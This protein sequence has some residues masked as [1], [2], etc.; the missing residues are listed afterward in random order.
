[1]K[2]NLPLPLS[3]AIKSVSRRGLLRTGKVA[4]SV[5]VDLGFDLLYG[6]DTM[7]WIRAKDLGANS[8]Y[9]VNAVRY[10]ATKARPLRKFMRKLDLP[11]DRVFTDLGSGKGRV[12]LI[13]AQLGFEK[14]VGIEFSRRLCDI[15]RQNVKIF[16][17]K[18][19]IT[20][21]IDVIESDVALYN[22]EPEQCIF[23]IYNPFDEVVMERLLM[24]L[25]GSL[26][27]FP[28]KI[29]LLYNTPIHSIVIENSAL[30]CSCKEFEIG[31]TEF[32]VYENF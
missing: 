5:I 19:G 3:W 29:W 14:I 16:A 8:E 25:R 32:R 28:R 17:T 2:I 11:R 23:F 12:L 9:D 27:R 24:N 31:G 22:I 30:F 18:T 6:T 26:E 10:Q 4:A 7:R 13:A 1:M 21:S 15:A 20:S